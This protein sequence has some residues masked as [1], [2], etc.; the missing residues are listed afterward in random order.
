[1]LAKFLYKL[2]EG[3]PYFPSPFC[4]FFSLL[5]SL[6]EVILLSGNYAP[7]LVSGVCIFGSE[8][9]C[10]YNKWLLCSLYFLTNKMNIDEYFGTFNGLLLCTN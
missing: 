5:A 9:I 1:M 2:Y 3:S 4:F 7:L 6:L 8:Y 10:T